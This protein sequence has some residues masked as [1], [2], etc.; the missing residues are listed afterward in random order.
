MHFLENDFADFMERENLEL[1]DGKVK[2]FKDAKWGILFNH[3]VHISL[4]KEYDD[5]YK[6][7]MRRIKKYRKAL[8]EGACLIRAIRDEEELKYIYENANHIEEVIKSYN[9]NNEIIYLMLENIRFC[10][11][12]NFDEKMFILKIAE[13]RGTNNEVLRSLFDT[14]PDF[15]DYCINSYDARRRKVNLSFDLKKEEARKNLFSRVLFQFYKPIY[16][17]INR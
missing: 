14:N 4:E 10:P 8:R 13:Y 1:V 17:I 5:I 2:E 3:D 16:K 6:K 11:P 9:K 15:I 7:Y 12:A